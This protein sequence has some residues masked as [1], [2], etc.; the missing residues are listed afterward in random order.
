[1]YGEL[2]DQ[3]DRRNG[4]HLEREGLPPR[5][6]RI[7]TPSPARALLAARGWGAVRMRVSPREYHVS[8]QDRRARVTVRRQSAST[9]AADEALLPCKRA[10][11]WGFAPLQATMGWAVTVDYS[12]PSAFLP[13]AHCVVRFRRWR[14]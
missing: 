8:T 4:R 5:I 7:I 6:N 10:R 1:M 3:T 12:A 2:Q 14:R 13:G 9:A 11:D